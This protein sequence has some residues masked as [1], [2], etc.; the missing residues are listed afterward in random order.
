[1]TRPIEISRHG[2]VALV[3]MRAG[4][5]NAMNGR[6]LAALEAVLD[7]LD[8]AHAVVFVGDGGSFSAGL[9]LPDLI[10][11]DRAG[12]LDL[13][14][15]FER[16]MRRVLALPIATVAAINGHA[17]AGG[18]VLALMCDARLMANGHAKIGL[19]EIVLGIG[20]PALVVEPLRVRVPA[21]LYAPMALEGRLFSADDAGRAHLVDETVALED[22]VKRALAHATMLGRAPAAYAQIKQAL[23]RPVL[24]AIDR[25]AA[26]DRAAWVETWFSPHAQ[27]T[28]RA[29]VDKIRKR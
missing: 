16:V 17:Y 28:L 2:T 25:S 18:C 21:H 4:K 3:E 11:L 24:D 15:H 5:A 10:D 13:I 22:L 26:A 1:M 7:E 14:T 23:L 8:D 29:A 27:A 9:A 6:F 12:I 19:N 20:L